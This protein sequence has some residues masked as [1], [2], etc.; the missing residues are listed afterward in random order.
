MRLPDSCSALSAGL[1]EPMA[2]TAPYAV[3]WVAI[4]QPGPWGRTALTDSRLRPGLGAR[5][6]RACAAA[7]VRPALL[8]RP[9]RDPLPPRSARTV[10]VAHSLPGRTWLLEADVQDVGAVPWEELVPAVATGDRDAAL[11][12]LAGAAP[13]RPHL[14]V[15]SNGRRDVCC[16]VQ[17][18]PVALA[19]GTKVPGQVWEATHL[20]GHRFAPTAAVLPSGTVHGRVDA[21]AA[22]AVLEAEELGEVVLASMR[23][24]TSWPGP[25]QA[26]EIAVRRMVGELSL[27]ALEVGPGGDAGTWHVRH[28]DGRAWQ[29]AVSEQT[30]RTSRPESCG[31][32][33]VPLCSW[34][35]EDP[36]P[37]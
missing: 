9:G 19:A 22:V 2:G 10:L 26:A 18:R 16:A 4:E 35:A 23:G 1:D 12:L 34:V 5:I 25:G 20:G 11:R 36:R 6:E 13:S 33:A 27:D 29:V 28:V 32:D 15:C 21:D 30:G 7:D 17:G 3:G 14:L 24:R 8:R 31:K 37:L